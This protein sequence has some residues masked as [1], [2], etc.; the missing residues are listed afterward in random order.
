MNMELFYLFIQMP[1]KHSINVL[2][3]PVAHQSPR[4]M[5]KICHKQ[6]SREKVENYATRKINKTDV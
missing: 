2:K 5:T 4:L 6:L 1:E 3:L